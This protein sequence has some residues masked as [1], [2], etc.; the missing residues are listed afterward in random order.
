VVGADVLSGNIELVHTTL[1]EN[2]REAHRK[3]HGGKAGFVPLS[4]AEFFK[5]AVYT[6]QKPAQGLA[7]LEFAGW[8]AI[9]FW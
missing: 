7:P 8:R 5:V 2:Q 9:V 4:T 3:Q 6:A 1:F